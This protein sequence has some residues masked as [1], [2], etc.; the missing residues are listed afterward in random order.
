MTTDPSTPLTSRPEPDLETP[1]PRE[2]SQPA[3]DR[4]IHRR[5]LLAAAA[6]LV[7]AGLA[8]LGERVASAGHDTDIAYSSQTTMHLDVV[9][10][11]ASSTRILTNI[12]GA[13]AM[14]V[15]NNVP[16]GFGR[17]DAI[18]GRTMYTTSNCAGVAGACDAASG[19]IGVLGAVS[20][21]ARTSSGSSASTR[22]ERTMPASS[23]AAGLN[24]RAC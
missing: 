5:G 23:R 14:I 24:T 13:A 21:S 22:A 20:A 6:A 4:P 9:N 17:P 12:S 7:G 8:W 18:L 19:G 3:A 11:T 10:T 16:V 15:L 1:A 2:A